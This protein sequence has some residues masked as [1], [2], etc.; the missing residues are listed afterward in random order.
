MAIKRS[1]RLLEKIDLLNKE[2]K[3]EQFFPHSMPSEMVMHVLYFFV[4]SVGA[5]PLCFHSHYDKH[6]NSVTQ[7]YNS[8]TLLV[9]SYE[10]ESLFKVHFI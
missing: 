10:S 5:S 8:H 2:V 6:L 7:S 1:H 9:M 3:H 4:Q